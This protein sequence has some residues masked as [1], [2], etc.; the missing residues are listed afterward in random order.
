[1]WV[2]VILITNPIRLHLVCTKIICVEN[3]INKE[4]K[5]MGEKKRRKMVYKQHPRT[6]SGMMYYE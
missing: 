6:L 4:K 1:M 5:K 3:L 2:Y